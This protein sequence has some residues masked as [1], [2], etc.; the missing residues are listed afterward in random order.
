MVHPLIKMG[1]PAKKRPSCKKH[2]DGQDED[3]S[4]RD[5]SHQR[6]GA[7]GDSPDEHDTYFNGRGGSSEPS[8][9][10]EVEFKV[11]H[12]DGEGEEDEEA[13]HDS[14]NDEMDDVWKSQARC[15][16]I[17]GHPGLHVE[18]GAGKPITIECNQE[19]AER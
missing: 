7:G 11:S 14:T 9:A 1:L 2:G 10:Q 8:I 6:E 17:G 16:L 12:S 5:C 4:S 19:D 15:V 18:G 3:L 13:A